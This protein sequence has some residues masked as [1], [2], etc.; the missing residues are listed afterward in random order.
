MQSERATF[1]VINVE[2]T[3]DVC[4]TPTANIPRP[5]DSPNG[6]YLSPHCQDKQNN[7]NGAIH[8]YNTPT[9]L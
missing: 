7:S 6:N 4:L 1:T 5:G 9:N 2:S 8:T 3:E